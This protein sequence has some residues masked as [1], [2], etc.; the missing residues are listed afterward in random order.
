MAE[1]YS[2][3]R[4][5]VF[6]ARAPG[7]HAGTVDVGVVDGAKTIFIFT[8]RCLLVATLLTPVHLRSEVSTVSAIC[9]GRAV[10]L[11]FVTSRVFCEGMRVG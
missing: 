1:T 8:P 2:L 11:N 9:S 4:S 10:R 3:F 7:L 5:R 6:R